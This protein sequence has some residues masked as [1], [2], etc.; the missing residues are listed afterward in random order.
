MLINRRVLRPCASHRAR[1]SSAFGLAEDLAAVQHDAGISRAAGHRHCVEILENLDRQIAPDARAVLEGRGAIASA[2]RTR[3][4]NVF[5]AGITAP[6]LK[7][8]ERLG[9]V[10]R[11][12]DNR[13]FL[14]QTLARLA[15][16]AQEL[17]E[18]SPEGTFTA[19]DVAYNLPS[20]SWIRPARIMALHC[21][22]D[23][24]RAIVRACQVKF[25]SG[26][27]GRQGQDGLASRPGTAI[28][29]FWPN[30]TQDCPE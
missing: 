6:S 13:F 1:Y 23:M 2:R 11:V 20:R 4:K 3:P 28:Q 15:E 22:A 21:D 27:A 7:R 24:V 12:A 8:A 25:L 10:A 26:P 16:I 14:P 30:N 18:G 19:G 5:A 9:R 29:R 17:A